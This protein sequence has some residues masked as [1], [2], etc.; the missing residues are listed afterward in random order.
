[1]VGL[2]QHTQP[3]PGCGHTHTDPRAGR[4]PQDV[5]IEYASH[6][7][8]TYFILVAWKIKTKNFIRER[9]ARPRKNC[10]CHVWALVPSPRGRA[11]VGSGLDPYPLRDSLLG[12]PFPT[13]PLPGY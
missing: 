7:I 1:M 5:G 9:Q 8:E 11:T 13:A 12:L 2:A 10:E 3:D 6:K 4:T